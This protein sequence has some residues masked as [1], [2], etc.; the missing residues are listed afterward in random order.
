LFIA[1]NLISCSDETESEA[2]EEENPVVEDSLETNDELQTRN[3]TLTEFPL[4]WWMVTVD[5]EEMSIVNHWDAQ[6]M[7]FEITA[8]T[9]TTGYIDLT[10]A[11][12]SDGGPLFDFKA[13]LS[14]QSDYLSLIDGSFSFVGTIETDTTHVT[15]Q[16]NR[17]SQCAEFKGLYF[18]SETFVEDS[19]KGVFP[20]AE[21]FRE[22][23]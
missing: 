19:L 7:K 6:E 15:F 8:E 16:Y 5:G 3:Y 9:E 1:F 10:Y 12:D 4:V 17:L 14:E 23:D 11:Q 2:T 21:T 22:D 20:Y 13:E 18:S